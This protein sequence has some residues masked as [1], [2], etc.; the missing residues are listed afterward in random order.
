M[1]YRYGYFACSHALRHYHYMMLLPLITMA[2]LLRAAFT[3]IML[4]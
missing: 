4:P 1:L 2:T 3:L